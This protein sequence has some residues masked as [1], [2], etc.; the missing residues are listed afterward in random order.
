[1]QLATSCIPGQ[2][3]LTLKRSQNGVTL[4]CDTFREL[5][6]ALA[7]SRDS[8][9]ADRPP[10]PILHLHGMMGFQKL[11]L[12]LC[13]TCRKESQ[14]TIGRSRFRS[15]AGFHSGNHQ[16]WDLMSLPLTARSLQECS[17]LALLATVATE[18]PRPEELSTKATSP[19]AYLRK[20][21]ISLKSTEAFGISR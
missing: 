15:F 2:R 13:V 17:P 16:Y 3:L 18:L 9:A 20:V 7:R 12:A 14:A 11:P 5:K 4:C 21:P 10:Q 19:L 1:M 6:F 8:M